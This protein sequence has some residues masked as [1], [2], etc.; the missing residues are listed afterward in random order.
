MS[1]LK[2]INL[3]DRMYMEYASQGVSC[4]DIVVLPA[5]LQLLLLSILQCPDIAIKMTWIFF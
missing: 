2:T 3:Q 5:V 1:V 4:V